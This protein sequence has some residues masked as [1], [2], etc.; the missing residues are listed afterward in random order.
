MKLDLNIEFDR[1][2]FKR[3]SKQLLDLRCWIDLT[4]VNKQR[5]HKTNR[6]QHAL[7]NLYAIEF[8]EKFDYVKQAVFKIV[9]NK[10]IFKR[11]YIDK[12]TGEVINYW[13]ST[14]D[15]NQKEANLSI[16]RFRNYA[17][18]NGCYLPTGDEYNESWLYYDKEIENAKQYL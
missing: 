17:S 1:Q 11:E 16:E 5:T 12:D 18:E 2:K 9:V 14:A 7:F 3:R 13:S 15:L 8:G 10:D 4:K 6:Y